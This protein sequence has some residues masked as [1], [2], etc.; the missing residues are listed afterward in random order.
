MH[1][2]SAYYYS[3]RYVVSQYKESEVIFEFTIIHKLN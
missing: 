1:D 3:D 2:T